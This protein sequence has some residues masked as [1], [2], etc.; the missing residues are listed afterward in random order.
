MA[1]LKKQQCQQDPDAQGKLHELKRLRAAKLHAAG[2][3]LHAYS[4]WQLPVALLRRQAALPTH[5]QWLS[6]QGWGTAQWPARCHPCGQTQPRPQLQA[7]KAGDNNER[8]KVWEGK[9]RRYAVYRAP[10]KMPMLAH[11]GTKRY[12]HACR[13]PH[14]HIGTCDGARR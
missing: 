12:M 2:S 9:W 8:N 3:T 4:A 11:F 13:P 5:M 6:A 14:T 7:G 10:T 1:Q